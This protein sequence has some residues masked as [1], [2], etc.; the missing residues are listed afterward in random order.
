MQRKNHIM[1]N[2]KGFAMLI[3]IALLII[4]STIMAISISMS[5]KT[6]Q[7]TTNEYLH[8]QAILL[9]SSATEYAILAISGHDRV[10]NDNCI[11]SINAIYPNTINPIFDINISISYVGF[12]GIGL[13]ADDCRDYIATIVTPE[14]NGTTLIDVIVTS[15]NNLNINEPIRYH[16]R[17]LQKL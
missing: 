10:A 11:N 6:T 5:T 2:H 12:G 16:R 17:T 14:T 4:I 7:R 8:E 13:N 3:A 15:N 1:T 9:A